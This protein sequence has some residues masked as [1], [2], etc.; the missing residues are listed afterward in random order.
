MSDTLADRIKEL[1]MRMLEENRECPV[2]LEWVSHVLV[3]IQDLDHYTALEI[4]ERLL[5]IDQSDAAPDIAWIAI[6]FSLFRANQFKNLKPFNPV[7]MQKL[8]RKA[9][10]DFAD[11]QCNI[12]NRSCQT[13]T[14][15]SMP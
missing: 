11:S 3:S 1:A 12:L 14:C 8:L 7:P 10:V 4:V 2:V 5:L 9:Q 6:Y 13:I 15:N